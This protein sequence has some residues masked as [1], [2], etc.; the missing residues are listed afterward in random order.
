MIKLYTICSLKAP[1]FCKIFSNVIYVILEYINFSILRR[2][3]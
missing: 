2:K 3:K 1:I